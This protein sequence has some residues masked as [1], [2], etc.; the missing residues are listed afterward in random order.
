MNIWAEVGASRAETLKGNRTLMFSILP[1]QWISSALGPDNF[2]DLEK[3]KNNLFLIN[4]IFTMESVTQNCK[5]QTQFHSYA[6][7]LRINKE[8]NCSANES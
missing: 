5:L 7:Y 1:L 2:R 4:A 8:P 3:N 6:N